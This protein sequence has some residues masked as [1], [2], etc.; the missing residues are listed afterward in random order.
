MHVPVDELLVFAPIAI[1]AAIYFGREAYL[2]L[3]YRQ[4]P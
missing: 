2:A 1:A 4:V 3:K